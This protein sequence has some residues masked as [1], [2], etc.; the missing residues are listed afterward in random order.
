MQIITGHP[1]KYILKSI[2]LL[3]F[4]LYRNLVEQNE[5]NIKPLTYRIALHYRLFNHLMEYIRL[6]SKENFRF[7]HFLRQS[8]IGHTLNRLPK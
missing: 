8:S 2:R 1:L 5:L 3:I 6:I 4:I 7:N